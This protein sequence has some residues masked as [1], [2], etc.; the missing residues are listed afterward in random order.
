[1]E[2]HAAVAEMKDRE[3]VSTNSRRK[4]KVLAVEFV[5]K[6]ENRNQLLLC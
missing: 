4:C 3:K 1:M 5:H 2:G 6:A